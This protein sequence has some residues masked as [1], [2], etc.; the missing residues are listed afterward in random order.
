MPLTQQ[1]NNKMHDWKRYIGGVIFIL[2]LMMLPLC[3]FGEDTNAPAQGIILTGE[4]KQD[5]I[6]QQM[7]VLYYPPEDKKPTPF[8]A[9]EGW[10]YEK[11]AIGNVPVERLV[12]P[13]SSSKSVVLQLHGGAYM[14][15]LTDLYR[16]FAVRQAEYTNAREIYC[17]DY[18]HAPIH[19]YPAALEDAATVYQ[20]LLARGTKPSNIIIFGDSAGGNLAVELA[21]YL[22]DEGLPQPAALILLSPWADF[23]HKDGTSRTENF[24]KD[25]VLGKG[26]PFA[27]HLRSIPPYAGSLPLDDPRLS[28]LHADLSNLPPMLIQT[29]GYDLLLTEDEQ[30]A[31]KVKAD[32]T[33][34][35]FTVYPEMPHVFPLVLPELAESFAACEEIREFINQYMR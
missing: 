30:L 35:T 17:V 12:P 20:G 28:P 22:R 19:R 25:K 27:P 34:V 4:A 7:D 24:T 8:I 16:V 33:N 23:A 13:N 9:P 15:G 26:T 31:E 6:Q 3:A 2:G 14:S 10:V 21:I 5:Y 18:R 29:G 1:K 11:T 32:G